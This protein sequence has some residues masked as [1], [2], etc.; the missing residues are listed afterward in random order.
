MPFTTIEGCRLAYGFKQNGP[1]SFV[2]VHGLGC[3]RDSFDQC[4]EME[5]FR[6]HSVAAI[7]LPGCGESSAPEDFSYAMKD[8]A[9]LVVK[10][11]TELGLTQ[12]ILVG[13]SMGGVICLYVAEALGT[14]VK[15]FFSLEGNLGRNDCTFSARVSA[16]SQ[17]EFEMSGFERFKGELK[18]TVNEEASIGLSNYYQNVL[19][20]DARSYYLSSVSLVKE[21]CEGRLRERFSDLPVKKWYIFG[22]RS[23]NQGTK[24]FLDEEGIPC[25]IVPESGH[26][27]MDDQPSLF[28]SMLFGALDK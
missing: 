9:D 14:R 26:F 11:I 3:S 22:D 5:A 1:E 16:S 12:I 8:Q 23:M 6:R 15:A 19:K 25:L 2:F 20:A 18:N 27:M 13:H 28:Y 7:D 4:F 17:E 21:S 24:A 10:W